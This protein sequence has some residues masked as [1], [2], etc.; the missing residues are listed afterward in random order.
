MGFCLFNNVAIAAKFVLRHLG[1]KRVL[2][3]DWDV[4]HGNGTQHLF[5]KDPDVAYLSVHKC[6][7]GFFPGT[8]QVDEVG[9]KSGKGFT[10]NVPFHYD[11]MGDADYLA[12]FHFVFL[13]IAREF[14]PD[15]VI[16]SAGFDCGKNDQIGPMSVSTKGWSSPSLLL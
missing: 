15:I 10:V 5:E 16:V 12:C 14:N 2:V 4:H 7:K 6:G 8:G 9:R 13:P 1:L 11:G 3:L